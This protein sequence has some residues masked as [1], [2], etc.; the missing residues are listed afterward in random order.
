MAHVR[1]AHHGILTHR[2]ERFHLTL[3]KPREHERNGEPDLVRVL[4]IPGCLELGLV[5]HDVH[6]LIAR[7]HIGK[8]SHITGTLDI[9]LSP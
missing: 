8:S 3:G 1:I 7:I 4:G 2:K 6:C 9:I 5:V